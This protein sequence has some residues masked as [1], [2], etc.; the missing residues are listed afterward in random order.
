MVLDDKTKGSFTFMSKK[1]YKYLYSKM[2]DK[3][4]IRRA[5]KKMRKGKA[6]RKTIIKIDNNLDYYIDF[7]YDMLLN[8]IP[9]AEHPERG[10]QPREHKPI[11][12][13]EHG[14]ERLIYK[15]DI[16]EQWVH[17]IIMQIL[18]PI[19]LNRF[20]HN[21]FGSIPKKGLHK[22]AKAVLKYRYKCK[23]AFKLDVRH[24]FANV[25]LEILKQKLEEFIEDE[26]FIYI[27][28]TSFK[29]FKK[30]F[31]LGY[32]LSQWLSNLYLNEI[33]YLISSWG[34]NHVRYVDDIVIFGNNKRKIRKCFEEIKKS[35]G[36]MRLTVK[37]N[38][39]LYHLPKDHISFLGFVF[40]EDQI[41]L[42]KKIAK[43]ILEVTKR[44][45]KAISE[46]RP[47]W[48]KDA[49]RLLSYL[50]WIK[51]SDG[52]AFYLRNIK[53]YIQIQQLKKIVS[54]YERRR[55]NDEM[56]NGDFRSQPAYA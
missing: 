26:W 45:K 28:M 3:D 40:T 20:H 50:G 47:I 39:H 42:R 34:F 48:I 54:K 21:S 6:K 52:Y 4:L 24:F 9:G 13:T 31:P 19:L 7:M 1:Q 5:Y 2:L 36:K 8:T 30:G 16:I 18:A 15:P 27:I 14:K 46:Y 53:P 51:H 43:H 32:Y 25:N 10:F 33:D 56:G 35:L 44:I 11:V 23:Y 29:W 41:R 37:D 12:I 38:Y 55:R 17:H 49:R 22:G